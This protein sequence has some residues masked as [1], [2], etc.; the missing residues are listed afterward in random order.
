MNHGIQASR[1]HR[2]R[3]HWEIDPSPAAWRTA[4]AA[5]SAS[6]CAVLATGLEPSDHNEFRARVAVAH[7]GDVWISEGNFASLSFDLRLPRAEV[8]IVLERSRWLC[9]WR[10]VWRAV[11]DRRNRP[12][13]PAGCPDRPD[14]EL[15]GY[16]WNYE[17]EWRPQVEAARLEYGRGIPVIRLR[18][19]RETSAFSAGRLESNTRWL[20]VTCP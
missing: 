2:L 17:K 12:D 14:R 16:I 9:L 11:T 15:M 10:V 20:T 1:H 13:L 4:R 3:R 6:R 7:A 5:G 18:S 19:D 8:M